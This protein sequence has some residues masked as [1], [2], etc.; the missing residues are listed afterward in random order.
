SKDASQGKRLEVRHETSYHYQSSV[1][2]GYSLAWL[3]PRNTRRQRLL[4]YRLNVFPKP[5]F[6]HESTDAFGNTQHYF[7]MQKAHSELRV[8]S[9]AVV[10]CKPAFDCT[11]LTESWEDAR[12]NGVSAGDGDPP[13]WEFI[14]ASEQVPLADEYTEYAREIF[15]PG[16]ALGDALLAFNHRVHS[17]FQYLPGSTEVDTAL[18]E[19]WENRAGVCQDFAHFG[20]A[21]LRG[22]G[23]AVAYVSGYLLTYAREGEKKNIGT[24]ASH[25]WFAVWANE[26]GWVHLDP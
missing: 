7:E 4:E 18:A 3:T 25:A 15:T 16:R 2:L 23:L 13:P 22:L 24:D 17:D 21:A 14:Y 26:H 5:R 20:I 11:A 12:P 19:V 6:L 1:S 10:E 9:R 8:Q